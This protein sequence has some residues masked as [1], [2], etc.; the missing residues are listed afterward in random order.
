MAIESYF[1]LSFLLITI[2]STV[3]T[4]PNY[5]AAFLNRSSFPAGF[6]FGTASSAYQ[7]EGAANEGG[8]EPSIW[9]TY[10]HR[11]PERI[12]DGSNGDVAID[13][14]H[15]YK[16]D[17]GIMKEMG[18]DAYRF[19]ISWP[20]I[21]PKGKLKGGVNREGIKYYNNLIDELLAKGIQPFITLFHWDL[22]QALQDEYGGFLSSKIVDDFQDYAEVCFKNFG[23][24]VKHWITLNEPWGFSNNGYATGIFAPGR[25]SSWQQL[26]CT[27]GDSATEPYIVGHNLL[28]AHAAAVKTYKNKYQAT[29]KG[30]IGITLVTHWFVPFS[31]DKHDQ[32]AA[33]RA[34]DFMFGWFM[35]PLIFGDYPN[36]LR[37]LVGDRLPKFSEEQSK[38][39]KGSIDFLG[40]NYYTAKYAAYLPYSNAIQASYLTDAHANL[41]ADRHGIPIGPQAASDWLN[42]YPRGIRD[43]L[44]YTKKKYKNPLI[45]ITE[46]GV[47]EYNN[48]T[49][50]LEEA[51]M[52]N[53]RIDFYFRHLS[54]LKKAIKEGANVKGYFAWSLLDNFEWEMGYS[55]RFGIHYVDYKNGLKRYPK[56][57]AL[58]FKNF[59]KK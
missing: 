8:R 28:L 29:Q 43:L 56:H 50:T 37:S 11:Y 26:N 54:F 36:T 6:L 52:D 51:L 17:V 31:N 46:N 47:D 38:M 13:S 58:W 59:L 32:H 5:D 4:T 23:D 34:L 7:Y 2:C 44:L 30:K 48:G 35:D 49:L 12:K 27:G 40:L 45:Y 19:S 21:L 24:R 15:R 57:S 18:L 16:E 39:V 53:M 20:R 33:K 25:C 3:A 1:R 14:Y 22:P 10:T 55:V 9:D 42:V 41:S